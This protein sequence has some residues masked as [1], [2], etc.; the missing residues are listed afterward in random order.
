[1]ADGMGIS[2]KMAMK[3]KMKMSPVS[4]RRQGVI[5]LGKSYV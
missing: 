2:I 4:L 3:I 1:M 5:Q